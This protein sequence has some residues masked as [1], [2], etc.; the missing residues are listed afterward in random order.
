MSASE[1]DTIDK[2]PDPKEYL[3]DGAYAR[4]TEYGDLVITTEDG[5]RV[6]NRVVLEPTVLL[7][8]EQFIASV[9][10]QGGLLR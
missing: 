3:G 7:T 1:L 8:L 6:Q 5:I 10:A 9:R 4:M 2:H